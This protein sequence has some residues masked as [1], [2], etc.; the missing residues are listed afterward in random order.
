MIDYSPEIPNFPAVNPFLPCYGKFDLTTYIQGAS[1]YEIMA[2]LV[3]LYNT[4]AK[5]YN[6]IQKL[7]VDTVTA[8]KQLQAFVNDIFSDP[9]LE[10][11]LQTVL[12]NMFEN[13]TMQ[14]YLTKLL[15]TVDPEVYQGT[16]TEKLQQ[17]INS[18]LIV[19]LNKSYTCAPLT[20]SKRTVIYGNNNAINFTGD[21]SK[22]ALSAPAI[23][24]NIL[25]NCNNTHGHCI[26]ANNSCT[27][28][29]CTITNVGTPGFKDGH[30]NGHAGIFVHASS[31]N[32]NNCTFSN[33]EYDG[34]IGYPCERMSVKNSVFTNCGRF[35]IVNQHTDIE[36]SVIKTPKFTEISAC[37]ISNCG[38]GGISTETGS[39]YHSDTVIN[40]CLITNCGNDDWG[41]GWSVA[42]GNFT[43]TKMTN[44][45][46]RMESNLNAVTVGEGSAAFISNCEIYNNSNC[47]YAYKGKLFFTNNSI[48]SYGVGL[49]IDTTS[50]TA[51]SNISINAPV[52]I[53]LAS[54]YGGSITNCT[55]NGTTGITGTGILTCTGNY[56]VGNTSLTDST[57]LAS[58]NKTNDAITTLS[59]FN[60]HKVYYSETYPASDFGANGDIYLLSLGFAYV[61][62]DGA[63]IKL[64]AS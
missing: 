64:N 18:G 54:V 42:C 59:F 12:T 33:I 37:D 47:V 38:S 46:I 48:T 15:Q 55:F 27:V 7:S 24:N 36:A 17:A 9:D 2:N 28:N 14:K 62:K 45:T 26:S 19:I 10:A 60:G 4:M 34:I 30:K 16:D 22:I 25:F 63:W 21:G 61:K 35:A 39:K 52:G 11:T 20:I 49:S 50:M 56:C 23:F 32:V 57:T 51:I 6:D 40:G 31:L 41:Y 5:G 44:T 58:I 29:N 1:D 43:S 3:Q 13:G 8:F 53:K